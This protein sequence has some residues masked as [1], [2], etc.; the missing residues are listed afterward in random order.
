[1]K[2]KTSLVL[3]FL[4]ISIPLF[5][6]EKLNDKYLVSYGNSKAK[7]KALQYFSFMCPFCLEL[8]QQEFETVKLKYIE[9][10]AIDY[11]FHP[12]PKDL[13]TV[14]AMDCLEKLNPVQKIAF[15]EVMLEEIDVEDVDFS[16]GLMKQAMEILGVPVK[17]LNEKSYLQETK[18]FKDAFLFLSQ[19]ETISGVPTIE[20]D[21]KLYPNDVPNLIFLEKILKGKNLIGE[22]DVN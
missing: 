2:I 10:N 18:A 6:F 22:S 13:L 1:M 7:T 11:T 5:S 19:E 20:L 14:C 12:V 4:I 17:R 15:L 3:L 8:Y 9:T 16:I 21:G